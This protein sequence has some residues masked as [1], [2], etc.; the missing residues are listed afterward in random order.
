MSNCVWFETERHFVTI[1][2]Q[3]C[4]SANL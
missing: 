1:C 4:F 2:F 3:L